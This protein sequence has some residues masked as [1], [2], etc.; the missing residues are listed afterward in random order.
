MILVFI[1]IS[2]VVAARL[3]CAADAPNTPVLGETLKLISMCHS[4]GAQDRDNAI[5]EDVVPK[6]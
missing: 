6:R 5:S 1:F 4:L 2:F 3:H